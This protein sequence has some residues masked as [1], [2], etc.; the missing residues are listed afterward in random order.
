VSEHDEME[1]CNGTARH[2]G[3]R[4][5][6]GRRA[7]SLETLVQIQFTF[8]HSHVFYMGRLWKSATKR[9]AVWVQFPFAPPIFK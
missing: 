3:N 4:L 7:R 2:E 9:A 6:E 8:C 5:I 1:R